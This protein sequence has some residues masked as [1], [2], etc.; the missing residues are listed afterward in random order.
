MLPVKRRNYIIQVN[1]LHIKR[2]GMVLDGIDL[3]I[4][5][6]QHWVILG[7]NGSGKTILLNTLTAYVTPSSGSIKVCGS[8]Y[9]TTDWRELRKK[10]GLVSSSILQTIDGSETAIEVIVSGKDAMVNYWGEI[11]DLD[12]RKAGEILKRIEC[13]HIQDRQWLH[14]SQGERQ[15]ICIGRAFMADMKILLLDEPC[16]GL[17]PLARENFLSFIED[18]L[19]KRTSPTIVLVTHHIEEITPSFTH[20]LILKSGRVLA[21]GE[22]E[23]V[24][25]SKVLSDAFNADIQLITSNSRYR[26]VVQPKSNV[27]I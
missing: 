3:Q 23:K 26:M 8:V 1:D 20:V 10:I 24:L 21:S 4:E 17:D 27:I 22:K 2:D 12:M 11:T 19:R 6:G 7:A 14:L 15:R 25:N 13:D 5:R 9:G 16:A 18:L